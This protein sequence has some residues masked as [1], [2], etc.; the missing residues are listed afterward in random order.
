MLSH[1]SRG[2]F[3][4]GRP[5]RDLPLCLGGVLAE[6]DLS[7]QYPRLVAGIRQREIGEFANSET[8]LATV[9]PIGDAP[10]LPPLVRYAQPEPRQSL[11]PV[12]D[13]P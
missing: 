6:P 12:F 7:Q 9:M 3:T 13:P 2:H 11:I 10:R 5:H 8:P 4:K 1:V